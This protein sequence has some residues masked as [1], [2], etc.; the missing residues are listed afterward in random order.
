MTFRRISLHMVAVFGLVLTAG[1]LNAA[2][3]PKP[4]AE[5]DAAAAVGGGN[6]SADRA[7]SPVR[8]RSGTLHND[9]PATGA[10][11]ADQV[12]APT[13]PTDASHEETQTPPPSPE[14]TALAANRQTSRIWAGLTNGGRAAWA[15]AVA[16]T[17]WVKQHPGTF[18]VYATTVLAAACAVVATQTPECAA[19]LSLADLQVCLEHLPASAWALGASA[20]V[21]VTGLATAGYD[22]LV[23]AG[24]WAAQGLR[25]A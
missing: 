11:D 25:L 23:A 21:G 12:V 24:T 1:I 9:A 19:A 17:D 14:A 16:G 8:A 5:A 10:A 3:S 2:T 22:R 20:V 6:D 13:A 7:A 18:A 4:E 15:Q